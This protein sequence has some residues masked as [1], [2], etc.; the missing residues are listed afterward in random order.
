MAQEQLAE[1]VEDTGFEARVLGRGDKDA[2]QLRVGGMTCGACSSGVEAAL[3]AAPGVLSASVNLI[4]GTA[5]ARVCVQ[6]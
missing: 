2:L 1:A 6:D 3:R 5:Q 4:A